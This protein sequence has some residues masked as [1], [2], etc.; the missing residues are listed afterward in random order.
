MPSF[1][2]RRRRPSR[3]MHCPLTVLALLFLE[4]DN[5][6]ARADSHKKCPPTTFRIRFW[7]N[8]LVPQPKK[9]PHRPSITVATNRHYV[10]SL[11]T[12]AGMSRKKHRFHA[13]SHSPPEGESVKMAGA[14]K[15][16]PSIRPIAVELSP[17]ADQK[18]PSKMTLPR[19]KT[20]TP[21]HNLGRV[22]TLRPADTITLLT[23]P[24][25]ISSKANP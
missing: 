24:R 22:A 21:I 20:P 6:G 23:P 8:V 5:T 19:A 14:S 18:T 1:D 4:K 13:V 7:R 12:E 15:Y 25:K 2:R 17:K 11:T 16:P 3:R 9:A 10:S